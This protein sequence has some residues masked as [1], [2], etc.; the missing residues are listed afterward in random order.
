MINDVDK[1]VW[2]SGE[3]THPICIE[4]NADIAKKEIDDHIPIDS[5]EEKTN[6]NA[7]KSSDAI[8]QPKK[9]ITQS[10]IRDEIPKLNNH[11]TKS[12]KHNRKINTNKPKNNILAKA[13]IN[14]YNQ[15]QIQNPEEIKAK[16]VK[17]SLAKTE[18]IL[19]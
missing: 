6:T 14:N 16:L 7:K 18:F 3:Q 8:V 5:A 12:I 19:K 17:E 11:N 9:I 15:T 2:L 13:R 1:D 4:S 10:T